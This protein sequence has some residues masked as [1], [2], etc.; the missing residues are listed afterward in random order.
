MLL[1]TASLARSD[2]D[3]DRETRLPLDPRCRPRDRTSPCPGT[4]AQAATP[5]RAARRVAGGPQPGSDL[6]EAVDADTDL[7]RGRRPR[8]RRTRDLPLIEGYPARP[9][10][11]DRRHGPRPLALLRRP[12]L[13]SVPALR[14]T[15]AREVGDDTGDQRARRPRTPVPG[16]GRPAD[17]ERAVER[18]VLR[19]SARVDRGWEQRA[20]V[21]APRRRGGGPRPHGRRT[22]R[23]P[24]EP[25]DR[26]QRAGAREIERRKD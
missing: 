17:D 16:D 14:R 1:E 25:D 8:P 5:A 23:L 9:G 21:A 4:G 10:R 13:P 12:R 22:R 11:D 19:P 7:L 24:G 20:S 15:R 18:H 2:D 26:P 6:R 3:S